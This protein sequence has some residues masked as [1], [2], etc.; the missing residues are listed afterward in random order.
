[1]GQ[2]YGKQQEMAKHSGKSTTEELARVRRTKWWTWE[3]L[4]AG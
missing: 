3:E 4:S 1:M 2:S